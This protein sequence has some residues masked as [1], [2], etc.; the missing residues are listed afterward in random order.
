MTVVEINKTTLL[1]RTGWKFKRNMKARH[2]LPAGFGISIALI[3]SLDGQQ[4]NE[5]WQV[6][7]T[8]LGK[9]KSVG[10]IHNITPIVS[11]WKGFGTS[12]F[13]STVNPEKGQPYNYNKDGFSAIA[14]QLST[15]QLDTQLDPPAHWNPDFPSID[16]L[17]A[18]FAVRPLV[19]ISIVDQVARRS[20]FVCDMNTNPSTGES[21]NE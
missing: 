8:A 19:V 17:P 5:L 11:V 3:T 15:D 16:E 13:A 2:F 14:Y 12:K 9:A 4:V 21:A 1:R 7:Q 6:Y 18:T 20:S 10:L